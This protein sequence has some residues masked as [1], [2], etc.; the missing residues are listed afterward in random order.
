MATRDIALDILI[1]DLALQLLSAGAAVDHAARLDERLADALEAP[2]K[3]RPRRE[4]SAAN[5][6]EVQRALTRMACRSGARAE[7]VRSLVL[8]L[9]WN[10]RHYLAR[11]DDRHA[12]HRAKVARP[13]SRR[14]R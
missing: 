6:L 5:R 2:A 13:G 11:R 8:T 1:E 10:L 12:G 4:E 3:R 7:D 9:E 14:T